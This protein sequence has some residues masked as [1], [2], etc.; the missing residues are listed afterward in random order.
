MSPCLHGDAVAVCHPKTAASIAQRFCCLWKFKFR[1]LSLLAKTLTNKVNHASYHLLHP[2]QHNIAPKL[3]TNTWNKEGKHAHANSKSR[4]NH[5]R[6]LSCDGG[7]KP[8]ALPKEK[9]HA[10]RDI[11]TTLQP[12]YSVCSLLRIPCP[13]TDPTLA[14]QDWERTAS[15]SPKQDIIYL[16]I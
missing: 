7:L 5:Q 1:V 8:I 14:P 9:L 10:T 2:K 15:G 11:S 4:N 13:P 3:L 16:G 6:E 12:T